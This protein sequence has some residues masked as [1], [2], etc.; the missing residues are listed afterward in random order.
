MLC[1]LICFTNFTRKIS[2]HTVMT[3][4]LKLYASI[5]ALTIA[6]NTIPALAQ[7]KMTAEDNRAFKTALKLADKTNNTSAIAILR[8][9][10]GKYPDNIGVAYNLGICY[11]NGSGNPDSTLYFLNRAKELDDNTTWDETRLE[12]NLA[13]ARA[14]QLCGRPQEALKIYD[15]VEAHDTNKTY[16]NMI[17]HE[18]DICASAMILMRQPVKLVMRTAGDGVNSTSNDYR[19]ILTVNEDTMYYTSRRPKQDADKTMLFDDGQSEE[20]I[21]FS[22]RQGNKWDGGNWG[23]AKQVKG[24]VTDKR[25]N[26]GQETAT[27]LSMAGNE[28]YL[29]HNGDI[30]VSR[31]DPNTGK[32]QPATA[33]PEPV[34]SIYNEDFAYVTPDGQDMFLS[35]DCPGG[36]GGKDIYRSHRLPDGTW[37]EPLNLGPG[38]NTEEDEDAPFFHV[39]SRILYFSSKGH[40]GMGGYDIFYSPEDKNGCF[41]ACTNI[42]FPINSAD[43]DLFFSPSVDRDRAYYSSIRWDEDSKMPSYDIYEVEYEQPEQNRMAVLAAMIKAPT[44]EDVRV[45]TLKD[46][47][48]I[49][50]GRPNSHSGRF[51]SIVEAGQSYDLMAYCDGDTITRHVDTK[52]SQSYYAQQKP[53]EL[54]PIIFEFKPELKEA[55]KS[56]SP[57]DT[58]AAMAAA[59][60]N[61]FKYNAERPYTVQILSLR[62]ILNYKYLDTAIEPDSVTEYR[63]QDGW[64]VYSYGNYA[65]YQEA[66]AVRDRIRRDTKYKD[67]FARNTK[68][69]LKY[70]KK[71]EAEDG[72]N[73]VAKPERQ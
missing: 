63:Y 29:C 19:P 1:I 20:G 18:R 9:L 72:A 3:S 56:K 50:L 55:N 61:S 35:S 7:S 14:Q 46:N 39:D 57:L 58:S 34:N 16:A 73:G 4:N 42:G 2:G 48:I 30:Y 10:Y 5:A 43:D 68:Q 32:W 27:S 45:L 66:K 67:A 41:V 21:Y 33:L 70:V 11:I 22:V 59:A 47:E 40:D 25:G 6:A 15:E 65:T 60:A 49:A 8:D 28:M 52:K 36:Y 62:R 23:E 31:K 53:V 51:V 12:L 54:D 64:F 71:E 17:S 44:I 38:V 24:L 69:Y 13:I 37:G 26:A